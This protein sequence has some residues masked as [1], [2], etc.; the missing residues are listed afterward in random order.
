MPI[1]TP[2]ERLG[3]TIAERYRLDSQ[4]CAGG[5]GV[6]F[7]ARDTRDACDVAV[8][9]LKP[10]H[11]CEPDRV[12]RFLRETMIA[13]R[14]VHPN[15]ARTLDVW[16]DPAGVPFLIMELL[17]GRT[18][19]CELERVGTLPLAKTL[20]IMGPI[21]RAL[22][23]VHG[24]GVIHRDVKPSNIFL[25]SEPD[26]STLP[27]LLDF[28][29]AKSPECPFETQTGMLLGTPGYIAPEQAQFGHASELTD[30]WAVGAVLYRCL[31]GHA[32]HAGSGMADT[33]SKLIHTPVPPLAAAGVSKRAAATIDRALALDPHRRYPSMKAFG[34]ALAEL[35]EDRGL[36]TRDLATSAAQ[37]W[38]AAPRK[39]G[40]PS[41]LA[42][43][44]SLSLLAFAPESAG[45]TDRSAFARPSAPP[46]P[47]QAPNFALVEVPPPVLAAAA[48]ES[49]AAA[50]AESTAAAAESTAAVEPTAPR[51]PQR[52]RVAYR[53]PPSA[54][55]DK[56]RAVEREATTGLPVAVEW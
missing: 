30:V 47:L 46:T 20:A 50:A 18:L 21:A 7:R 35:E 49:T 42:A 37:L 52:N 27:K 44:L 16:T 51:R 32:P 38:A 17:E 28:G 19:A 41:A 10:S 3:Q 8:K 6:L 39:T 34:R 31:T 12:A 2:E 24:L 1:L 43:A 22:Q 14:V 5:M 23:A 33:F 9:M 53:Q 54:A 13:R 4:L 11:A 45:S 55:A 26:G 25:C 40:R 48:A 15:V 36:D 56:P 29:I